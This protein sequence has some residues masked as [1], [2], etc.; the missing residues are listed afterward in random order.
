MQVIF[1]WR[2]GQFIDHDIDIS[3]GA[4]PEELALISIPTGD[5]QFDPDNTG[6]QVMNVNR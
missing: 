5:P 6:N 4:S 2:W 1:L 3:D